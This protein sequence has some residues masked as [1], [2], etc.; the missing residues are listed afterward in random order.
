MVTFKWAHTACD[1]D[2][3]EHGTGQL[4]AIVDCIERAELYNGREHH[5]DGTVWVQLEDTV[6]FTAP[7]KQGWCFVDDGEGLLHVYFNGAYIGEAVWGARGHW[8]M[9]VNIMGLKFEAHGSNLDESYEI[10]ADETV[11]S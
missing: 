5:I 2:V 1:G 11:S 3:L 8:V 10:T 4:T 7:L 6:W 9:N